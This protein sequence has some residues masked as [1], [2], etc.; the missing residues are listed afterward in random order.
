MPNTEI[1]ELNRDKHRVS[2][3]E[4]IVEF[5]V[6]RSMGRGWGEAQI[7]AATKSVIQHFHHVNSSLSRSGT[8]LL[9][10]HKITFYCRNSNHALQSIIIEDRQSQ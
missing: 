1:T 2:L 9:S 10:C 4:T 5:E 6:G 8:L 3:K 7:T